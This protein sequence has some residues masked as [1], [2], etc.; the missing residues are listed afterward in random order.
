MVAAKNK[1]IQANSEAIEAKTAGHDGHGEYLPWG[2][3]ARI[4]TEKFVLSYV[5]AMEL[6]RQC[7]TLWCEQLTAEQ[8]VSKLHA[9]LPAGEL[10]ALLPFGKLQA[11]QQ[12]QL[13]LTTEQIAGELQALLPASELQALLPAGKLQ[14]LQ[15][16]RAL[17]Q[18][19]LTTE[20][21]AEKL[22]TEQI[23]GELLQATVIDN[24]TTEQIAGELQ[25]RH[26]AREQ[27]TTE[28]FASELVRAIGIVPR[29]RFR[30]SS[31]SC[32][33]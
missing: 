22:A 21:I 12:Q 33:Q 28:Q 6:E 13:N 4:S 32:G 19:N 30:G 23:A 29:L 16:L 3:E 27:L 8:L 11:L 31:S 18:L 26:P 15:Q 2:V 20:Q 14:A 10:P 25:A 17:H 24:T 7:G 1:E 5:L 9:L